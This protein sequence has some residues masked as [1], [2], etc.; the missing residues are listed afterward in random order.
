MNQRATEPSKKYI[1]YLEARPDQLTEM[2]R[3]NPIAYVPFG[4][5]EWHGEH[6]PLGLDGLKAEALC[7]RMAEQTGGVLF[8]CAHWGAFHN[9]KFDYS[10]QFSKRNMF[11]MTKKIA[12][13]LYKYGFKIVI[14]L[15]GHYPPGQKKNVRKAA[16]YFRKR[17]KDTFAIGLSEQYPVVDMNYIGDHAASW[18]TSIMLELF[19]DLVDLSLAPKGLTYFQRHIKHGTWGPDPATEASAELGK[20]VVDAIVSRMVAAI[21]EVKETQSQTPFQRIY[22]HYDAAMKKVVGLD[23]WK[24]IGMDERKDL[25]RVAKWMFFK[26]SKQVKDLTSMKQ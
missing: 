12:K 3:S 8:P 26:G 10:F 16:E 2:I 7:I 13:Q 18:E 17:G 9:L 22:D 15:T 1:T 25:F 20:Q 14:L 21:M 11:R 19:P 6:N 24:Y 4:A 23:A 5:L